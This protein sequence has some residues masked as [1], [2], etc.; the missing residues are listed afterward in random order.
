MPTIESRIRRG[1]ERL[2]QR[3]APQFGGERALGLALIG[4]FDWEPKHVGAGAAATASVGAVTW[5][6]RLGAVAAL[7]LTGV[8]AW[9]I[10]DRKQDSNKNEIVTVAT[11]GPSA[12]AADAPHEGDGA[13]SNAPSAKTPDP[14]TAARTDTGTDDA[15]PER[16]GS[17]DEPL[18]EPFVV[19]RFPVTVIDDAE[20]P[21]PGATVTLRAGTWTRRAGAT[22]ADGVLDLSVLE[23]DEGFVLGNLDG[24]KPRIEVFASKSGMGAV[25]RHDDPWPR[26]DA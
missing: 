21:V 16:S 13:A 6:L 4:A 22:N 24:G 20:L 10:A 23:T 15:G 3:L 9:F 19:H 14:R 25:V 5:A 18:D 17:V 12:D 7:L 11:G 8:T 26:H 1:I 2:R